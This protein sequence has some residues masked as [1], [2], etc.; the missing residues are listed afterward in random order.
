MGCGSSPLPPL[1]GA[2]LAASDT[3]AS[4]SSSD[5]R[6]QTSNI[7]NR[8]TPPY[9]RRVSLGRPF[10][11]QPPP[12]RTPIFKETQKSDLRRSSCTPSSPL[13]FY[14]A[15]STWSCPRGLILFVPQKITN[16]NF[17]KVRWSLN[18]K[19]SPFVSCSLVR[20]DVGGKSCVCVSCSCSRGLGA[21]GPLIK[22]PG[23]ED[24]SHSVCSLLLLT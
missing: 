18:N 5:I 22:L 14:I 7:N 15:H 3:P 2:C 6:H 23:H 10:H 8:E 20:C 17:F 11:R 1:L 13:P 9:P 19:P 24:L 16:E 12:R 21:Q 4:S